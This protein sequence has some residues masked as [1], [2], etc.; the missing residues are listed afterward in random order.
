MLRSTLLLMMLTFPRLLRCEAIHRSK[1]HWYPA[2]PREKGPEG[3]LV[4]ELARCS[5][6]SPEQ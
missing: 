6:S 5:R 4:N 2:L 1:R 3:G